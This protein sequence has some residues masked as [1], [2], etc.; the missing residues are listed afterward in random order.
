MSMGD[1]TPPPPD[2]DDSFGGGPSSPAGEPRAPPLPAE[3]QVP[4]AD[5]TPAAPE[6]AT[7]DDTVSVLSARDIRRLPCRI[8]ACVAEPARGGEAAARHVARLRVVWSAVL[9]ASRQ[10]EE[11]VHSGPDDGQRVLP[12]VLRRDEAHARQALHQLAPADLWTVDSAARQERRRRHG[13][14]VRMTSAPSRLPA[15][16]SPFAA[17]HPDRARRFTERARRR[18][19][20]RY[21][22]WLLL[23]GWKPSYLVGPG[24]SAASLRNTAPNSGPFGLYVAGRA[25]DEDGWRQLSPDRLRQVYTALSYQTTR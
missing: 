12:R 7:S 25:L 1:V 14:L 11:A 2:E 6:S 19:R 21:E 5:V 17:P 22:K 16:R 15:V 23:S 20:D 9:E 3:F 8:G 13:R 4:M 18:G 24:D 10:G